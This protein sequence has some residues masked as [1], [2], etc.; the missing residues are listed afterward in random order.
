[1]RKE[2]DIL[3]TDNYSSFNSV[4]RLVSVGAVVATGAVA[5]ASLVKLNNSAYLKSLGHNWAREGKWKKKPVS[6][7][8]MDLDGVINRNKEIKAEMQR[9]ATEDPQFRRFSDTESFLTDVQKY[10]TEQR[11]IRE[12]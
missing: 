5:G 8:G 9:L 12:Q 1:M 10:D 7:F 3:Y 2:D 6:I 11:I 4:R